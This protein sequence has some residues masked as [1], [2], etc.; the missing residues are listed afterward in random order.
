MKLKNHDKNYMLGPGE[1]FEEL[2]LENRRQLSQIIHNYTSADHSFCYLPIYIGQQW[3][4]LA[5]RSEN[6]LV[7]RQKSHETKKGRKNKRR[8]LIAQGNIT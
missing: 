4:Y 5:G 7:S 6:L 8:R 2:D 1:H 3:F